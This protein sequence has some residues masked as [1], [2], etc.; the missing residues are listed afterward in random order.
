M[1][2]KNI[3]GKICSIAL[4][5]AFGI[6][7]SGYTQRKTA[8]FC[9]TEKH[10]THRNGDVTKYTYSYDDRWQ[11][12]SDC[13][14]LN[15]KEIS[16][17]DYFYAEEGCLVQILS[18]AGD[19]MLD[20]WEY[21]MEFDT[22]GNL[23][24]CCAYQNGRLCEDAEYTYNSNGS[25]TEQETRYPDFEATYRETRSYDMDGNLLSVQQKQDHG[26]LLKKERIYNKAGQPARETYLRDETVTGW[27]EFI[28]SQDGSQMRSETYN[29][30]GTLQILQVCSYDD[31][32]NLLTEEVYSPN[33]ELLRKT[34]YTY[35]QTN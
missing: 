1:I 18:S 6:L 26:W 12:K 11:L 25:I 7:M 30:E 35:L 21:R 4:I 28:Y 23:I 3:G 9:L 17:N 15:N 27:T 22:Q 29:T 2:R 32:G 24:R 8:A 10:I 20:F 5:L 33:D 31:H 14:Y 13:I 34:E 19:T 16:R